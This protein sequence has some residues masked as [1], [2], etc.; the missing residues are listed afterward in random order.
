MTIEIKA[1]PGTRPKITLEQYRK[2][3]ALKNSKDGP[4]KQMTYAFL[5]KQLGL[6]PSSVL[7][8]ARRGIKRYDYIL[9]KE[10]Q[11]Q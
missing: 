10:K 11:R 4:V 8:A 9:W 7:N 2:I 6:R 5:A 1:L 3:V